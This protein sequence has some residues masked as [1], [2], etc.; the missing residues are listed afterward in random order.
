[1]LFEK[2]INLLSPQP[3]S[4]TISD[5]QQVDSLHIARGVPLRPHH[6]VRSFPTSL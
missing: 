1:M 5:I 2:T 6:I 4:P 3:T